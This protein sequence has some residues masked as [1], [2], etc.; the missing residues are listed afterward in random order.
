MSENLLHRIST[1]G[2]N[3]NRNLPFFPNLVLLAALL[4]L[5][6]CA[7][8]ESEQEY[9]DTSSIKTITVFPVQIGD[10]GH[11]Y[12]NNTKQ[13]LEAGADTLTS[14]LEEYLTGMQSDTAF[15]IISN[16]QMESLLG[17][18]RGDLFSQAKYVSAQLNSDA[19]LII[20]LE[21][22]RERAGTEYS[23]DAPASV[24]FEYKLIK[25]D[26]HQLL[27][28]GVFEETQEALFSNLFSLKKAKGRK[29]KWIT[30]ADLTREGLKTKL[31]SCPYL[32]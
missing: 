14:L 27:C 8:I 22:F 26:R 12:K 10:T 17:E 9:V 15:Q 18:H 25:S 19:A 31:G 30:A 13:Q 23:V 20:I 11:H 4:L 1:K 21:R 32:K 16:H 28:S 6:S 24:S 29:F 7:E 5:T 2:D 3:V